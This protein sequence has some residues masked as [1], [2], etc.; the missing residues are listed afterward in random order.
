DFTAN[1]QNWHSSLNY[2]LY[3]ILHKLYSTIK[4]SYIDMLCNSCITASQHE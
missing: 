2:F 1:T 4:H 3:F